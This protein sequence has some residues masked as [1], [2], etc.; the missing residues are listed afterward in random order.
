MKS[1]TIICLIKNSVIASMYIMLTYISHPLAFNDVQFR[2]SE[3]L[4]LFIFINP[5]YIFGLAIGTCIANLSSPI[6]ITDAVAGS[7]VSA[8]S[9]L[10]M[11]KIKNTF[12]TT[13]AS[14]FAA[15]FIPAVFNSIYVPLA[16]IFVDPH[17]NP[18]VLFIPMASSIAMG[19]FIVV[20]IIGLPIMSLI[21]NNKR[22]Y[23]ICN[24][25]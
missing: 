2:I 17:K 11:L 20:A 8:F 6:G 9:M 14:M 7:I 5:K 19:E 22:I 25:K 3:V 23:N 12:G 13:M 21:I 4:I 10:L 1:K 15:S 24:I 18:L 16:M